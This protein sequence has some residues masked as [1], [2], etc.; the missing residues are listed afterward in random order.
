MGVQVVFQGRTG[1]RV[2]L[3]HREVC[4]GPL[5][6]PLPRLGVDRAGLE[7]GAL[8]DAFECVWRGWGRGAG[9][10]AGRLTAVEPQEQVLQ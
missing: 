3:G 1:A 5:L 7:Q 8:W 4:W 9:W 6:Q 2:S 10:T